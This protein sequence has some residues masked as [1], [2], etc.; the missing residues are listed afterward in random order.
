MQCSQWY[1]GHLIHTHFL[2]LFFFYYYY[3][4]SRF[5]YNRLS[6][7]WNHHFSKSV[8]LPLHKDIDERSGY[9]IRHV[10]TFK[11]VD[12]RTNSFYFICDKQGSGLE[13]FFQYI[14]IF[15][16]SQSDLSAVLQFKIKVIIDLFI[17]NNK[18]FKHLQ[19]CRDTPHY[20][21]RW[22]EWFPYTN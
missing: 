15:S 22:S 4:F 13:H 21:I 11:C 9:W 2:G 18:L 19:Y 1:T 14:L 5:R 16:R 7:C 20:P 10:S 8:L 6:K 3:S 12:E 17:L